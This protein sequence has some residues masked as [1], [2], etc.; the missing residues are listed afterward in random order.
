[1]H[2]REWQ[3]VGGDVQRDYAYE[4]SIPFWRRAT[5]V[6]LKNVKGNSTVLG[7]SKLWLWTD[8]LKTAMKLFRENSIKFLT[9]CL[10]IFICSLFLCRSSAAI[11]AR[12]IIKVDLKIVLWSTVKKK[13][14]IESDH[15]QR[16]FTFM[17]PCFLGCL[18]HGLFLH[19]FHHFNLSCLSSYFCDTKN[20]TELET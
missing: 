10:R 3:W 4:D 6:T 16:M 1:M 9:C 2:V 18:C 5:W 20:P 12:K 17:F 15:T 11:F 13:K 19:F 14:R 7:A 8:Q